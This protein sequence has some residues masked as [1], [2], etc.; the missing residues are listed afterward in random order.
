MTNREAPRTCFGN[1]FPP[2]GSAV[3]EKS[4]FALYFFR[5]NGRNLTA[6]CADETDFAQYGRT[7]LRFGGKRLAN[8]V[9]GEAADYNVLAEFGN[10]SVEQ[11]F[12]RDVGIFDETLFE[13]TDRAVELVELSID[14]FFRHVCWLS[15][16]L[17]LVNLA[18]GLDQFS[19]HIFAT[20][21]KRM[22]RRDVQ[23]DVFNEA[24]KI[25]VLRDKI[26]FA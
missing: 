21:V 1:G 13:Q 24:A 17:R 26:G 8:E 6:D 19:R 14:D 10:F 4:R 12:D 15:F 9:T 16:H 25:F 7:I 3:F 23:R 5:P 11:I 2:F 22:R 18:L 20:D